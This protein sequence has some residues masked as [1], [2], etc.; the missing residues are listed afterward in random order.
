MTTK[1]TFLPFSCGLFSR[2]LC[3]FLAVL[4]SSSVLSPCAWAQEEEKPESLCVVLALDSSGSME[5]NDPQGLR[6]TAAQLFVALLDVGD[7]VGLIDFS[8]GSHAL[9]DGLVTIN[10]PADKTALIELLAPKPPEG[11]TDIKAALEEA[12][13]M[14][15]DAEGCGARTLV[16]LTDGE[17]EIESK[18]PEY[19]DEALEVARELGVPVMSIALTPEGESVFLQQLSGV[20]DPPGT[21]IPAADAEAL[22]DAYLDV[23]GMLKDRTVSGGEGVRA[24]ADV[25]LTIDPALVPY[26]DQVS[27]VVSM[28]PGVKATLIAPDGTVVSPD[29]PNVIFSQTDSRFAVYTIVEPAG[30]DWTFRLKGEGQALARAVLRSRLRV[31]PV[32]PG[33]FHPQG[34]PMLIVAS[35]IEEAP[36]GTSTILIGEATFSALIR[37]PDGAREALDLLYDDGTHGDVRTSDGNFTGLY[38][39]TDLPG[40]YEITLRGRK[41]AVPATGRLRVT[42]VPFPE[43]AVESPETGRHEVRGEPLAFSVALTGA[44]P[45]RLDRGEVEAE[46]TTPDGRV[47]RLPLAAS[48]EKTRYTGSYLPPAD[49]EYSVRFA[50]AGAYY[51]GVAYEAEIAQT[52]SVVLVPTVTILDEAVDLG[53]IEKAQMVKGVSVN[54]NASSTSQATERITVTLAGAPGV[55]LIDVQPAELGPVQQTRLVLTLQG[56]DVEPGSYEATLTISVRDGIDLG[57]RQIPLRFNLYAPVLTIENEETTFDLGEIRADQLGKARQVQLDVHSSSIQGEPLAVESVTGVKGVEA[58]L[59]VDTLPPGKTT[60][61]DLTLNLPRGLGEGEYQA[62]VNLSTREWAEVTPSAV[63]VIWSV[64]PVPWI[65]L[66]G[67]PAALGVLALLGIVFVSIIAIRRAR[68]QRPWGM[69]MVVAT[70]PGASKRDYS[71]LQSDR[72]G[73]VFVGSKRRCQIR[74]KH[75]SIEPLHAAIFAKKKRVTEQADA[76]KRPKTVKKPVCLVRNLGKGIVEVGGVRLREGQVSQPLEDKTQV[77]IGDFEFHWRK[78]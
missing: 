53:T 7:R 67:L 5:R 41:G 56:A 68:V 37:R 3:T 23:L 4:L 75:S 78:L 20:T 45:A 27:F 2:L 35:L 15:S 61:V 48:D 63:T 34:R 64:T 28:S 21:V 31:S 29:D 30:G 33:P 60:T 66:Y 10:G 43:L 70:P 54:L 22:L 50:L 71:L 65:E 72:Y 14:L 19:E 18:Y 58:A 74:L 12:A 39:N 57:R 8:T 76:E 11:Y 1:T 42:V 13:V 6:F 69:L 49:G 25:V 73:R 46:I 17:P 26:I 55:K 9:T 24:P 32:G 16:L 51:K 40:V 44:E 62:V 36:D 77:K 59:S 52:F 47:V 38:V